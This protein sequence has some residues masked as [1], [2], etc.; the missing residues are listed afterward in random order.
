MH[1][2]VDS[3]GEGSVLGLDDSTMQSTG[4]NSNHVMAKFDQEDSNLSFPD[5]SID[6]ELKYG[7]WEERVIQLFMT[8]LL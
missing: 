1:D 8:V 3:M 6:S 7:L 5:N 2:Y 4:S